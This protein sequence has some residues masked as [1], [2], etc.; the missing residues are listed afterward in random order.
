MNAIILAAGNSTRMNSGI[1]K[2][3][4][5][6]IDKPII[7]YI[8]RACQQL[9]ME[10]IYVVINEHSQGI[11]ELLKGQVEFVVQKQQLGTANAV[12]SCK[13]V[14]QRLSGDTLILMGDCPLIDADSLGKL[15]E[16]NR[17]Y[18]LTVLTAISNLNDCSGKIVRDENNF[19]E[20]IVESNNACIAEKTIDEINCGAYCVKNSVLWK[21]IS[22]VDT[23][24]NAHKLTDIIALLV[25][26]NLKVSTQFC[27]SEPININSRQDLVTATQMLQTKIYLKHLNNGVTILSPQTVLIGEDVEIACDVT[28]F[29]NNTIFGKSKIGKNSVI[30]GNNFF[31]NAVIGEN[32]IVESSKIVNSEIK[33]HA[34]IGPFAH[35]KENSSI[36]DGNRIGAF[37]EVKN[38]KLH[39][40][41]KAAHLT[42]LGDSEIEKNVNI[43]CGVVTVNYDGKNK[44]RTYIKENSF[45]GSNVNLIA[46]ITVG[47]D[48]VI[49]AGSTVTDDVPDGDMAIARSYQVNKQGYGKTYLDKK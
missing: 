7:S 45:I 34:Q 27:D 1:S 46:P 5:N 10:K 47:K 13:D 42:Y 20:K 44:N 6:L 39:T 33:N 37:V 22:Y 2:V 31:N 19:I 8:I 41:V 28:I 12:A 16:K 26:S 49:A 38:S 24:K 43:G 35:I 21:F 4:H 40:C 3:C 9:K 25:K 48:C 23:D 29:P 15:I 14:M 32:C 18:D 17:N 11:V 36:G 30:Y